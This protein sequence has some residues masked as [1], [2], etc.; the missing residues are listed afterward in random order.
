MTL[1]K[2]V[3]LVIL[4]MIFPLNLVAIWVTRKA[5]DTTVDQTITVDQ[6][7]ASTVMQTLDA[8]VDNTIS[9]LNYFAKN[10]ANCIQMQRQ[11]AD[12]DYTTA[13]L[14]FF[15]TLQKLAHMT[16]GADGYFYHM[17]KLDD[18]LVCRCEEGTNRLTADQLR[19][20]LQETP[21]RQW[22]LCQIGQSQYLL[23]VQKGNSTS[24][25]AWINLDLVRNRMVSNINDVSTQTVFTY[26]TEEPQLDKTRVGA[27]VTELGITLTISQNREDVLR[28][29]SPQ[30]RVLY[31][32]AL[33]YLAAIPLLCW[34]IN[35]F[36]L[37]PLK[38][39]TR[40]NQE[41][42][43][44]NLDYRITEKGKSPEY[45]DVFASFNAMAQDLK[46]TKFECYQKET[47]KQKL[48]LR[49]LQLQIRPHFLL[50]IFNL[51]YTLAQRN[52]SAQ[53]E[54]TILYLSNYFRYLFRGNSETEP[55]EKEL[56]IIDG[57]LK[58]ANF[59]Y[60]NTI[61]TQIDVTDEVKRMCIPPL[62]LHNFVENTVKHG[63][64]SGEELHILLK[65]RC[66]NGLVT[67]LIADDGSGMDEQT[68]LRNRAIFSN[69]LDLENEKEHIGLYDTYRRLKSYFGEQASIEV[70]SKQNQGTSF[71]VC[72]PYI[73][74]G[75]DESAD[76]Q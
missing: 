19:S 52:Q 57:Y 3:I 51:I 13:K 39:V 68:L 66:E 7:M 76:R 15:V 40:A 32:T 37:A 16:D 31:F 27:S 65:G 33:I 47:E 12:D 6:H 49:N 60:R 21:M 11:I 69:D 14:H 1:Y 17:Q 45:E 61:K 73:T 26:A 9:L 62:L 54:D 36:L 18:I 48:A 46:T 53:I 70:E 72:F 55:I 24:Y 63:V 23:Y 10:D 64:R 8:R 20:H 67:F 30:S 35:R 56:D 28:H 59:R 4:L 41:I 71:T 58:V 34:Y 22:S 43:K 29:I 44:G 74:G 50:N 2:K 42:Q 25:G 5:M 75:T 38:T